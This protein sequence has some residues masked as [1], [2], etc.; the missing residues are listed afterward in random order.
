MPVLATITIL[1]LECHADDYDTES[2]QGM[3]DGTEPYETDVIIIDT[4]DVDGD[5]SKL[6]GAIAA[7]IQDHGVG[8]WDGGNTGYDPDGSS[9]DTRGIVTER[10]A[11]IDR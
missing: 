1:E 6:D 9:M 5:V 8:Q 10:F 2:G 4:D 3:P 11:R 7:V